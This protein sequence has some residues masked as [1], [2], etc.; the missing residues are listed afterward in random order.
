MQISDKRPANLTAE[1]DTDLNPGR[2]GRFLLDLC[3]PQLLVFYPALLLM[4]LLFQPSQEKLD[5]ACRL[6]WVPVGVRAAVVL[7]LPAALV[8][9]WVLSDLSVTRGGKRSLFHYVGA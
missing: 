9:S 7:L 4:L 3:K 6:R 1:E 5:L 8:A 2:F